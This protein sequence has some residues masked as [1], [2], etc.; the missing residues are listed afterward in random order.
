MINIDRVSLCHDSMTILSNYSI[1]IDKGDVV[2][3]MG[4]M[5][6]VKRHC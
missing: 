4:L 1:T 3:I 5:V 2:A 6:S